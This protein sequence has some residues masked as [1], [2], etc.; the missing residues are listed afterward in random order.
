MKCASRKILFSSFYL[1]IEQCMNQQMAK[2]EKYTA[3]NN[4]GYGG[5]PK[6]QTHLMPKFSKQKQGW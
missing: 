4:V 6:Q 3:S 5:M 2:D 1:R